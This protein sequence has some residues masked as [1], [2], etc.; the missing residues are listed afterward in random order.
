MNSARLA[1]PVSEAVSSK[2]DKTVNRSIVLSLKSKKRI[3]PSK[4][5]D[6]KDCDF[7]SSNQTHLAFFNT[8]H[9][10]PTLGPFN[11]THASKIS[12]TTNAMPLSRILLFDA[13]LTP[14]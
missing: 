3:R 2:L 5:N 13:M 9:V 10:G 11:R 14:Q 1:Q 12:K 6:G 4:S 7:N 8:Q